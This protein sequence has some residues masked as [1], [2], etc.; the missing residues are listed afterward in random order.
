MKNTMLIG[1]VVAS[2]ATVTAAAETG[3]EQPVPTEWKIAV[4]M[5]GVQ[6][7]ELLRLVSEHLSGN[8]GLAVRNPQHTNV[9]KAGKPQEHAEELA[10]LLEPTDIGLVALMNIPEKTQFR[11]AAFLSQKVALL[12]IWALRPKDV[13]DKKQ[14]YHYSWRVRKEAIRVMGLLLGL[15]DCVFPRCAMHP[16]GTQEQVDKKGCN[17]CPPCYHR[18]R[19]YLW[20]KGVKLPGD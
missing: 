15:T 1:L 13:S 6:D 7:E 5:I 2:L 10:R 3:K 4:M 16:A 20:A 9:I 11:Q 8:L 19:K 12:N 18:T 14:M 17:L